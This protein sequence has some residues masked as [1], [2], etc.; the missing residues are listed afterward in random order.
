MTQHPEDYQGF[1][2]ALGIFLF[3]IGM[4]IIT[5]VFAPFSGLSGAFWGFLGGLLLAGGL[6]LIIH[7]G[8]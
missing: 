8:K 4:G 1:L 5:F 7:K 2:A 3:A 6:E